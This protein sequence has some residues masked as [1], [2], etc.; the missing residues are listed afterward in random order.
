MTQDTTAAR[1]RQT[2]TQFVTPED[3]LSYELG[4]AVRQLPPLYTRL[5]AGSISLTVFSTIAWAHLSHIDEVAVAPGEL[6]P[7]AQV[8][9][10]RSLEGGV[11]AEILVEEGDLVAAGEPLVVQDQTLPQSDVERLQESAQLV[12]QDIARLQSELTGDD[13]GNTPLQDQLLAARL[14][15][16]R[17]QQATADAEVDRLAAVVGEA[18]A[19]LTQLQRTLPNARELLQNAQ[20]REARLRELSDSGAVARFDY[21][22]AKDRLTE[23]RN[24]VATVEQDI[25]AQ[26]QAVAQ[27]EQEA[28]QGRQARDRL[29]AERRSGILTELNRRTEELTNLEGQLNQAEL[30]ADAKIITAPTAG[31][32]YNIQATLAERTIEPGEELLSILPRDEELLLEAKILNRDIGFVR[33]GMTAKIKLDTFPFQEFGTVSG[34]VTH[35]SPNATVDQQLGPVFPVQIQLDEAAMTIGEQSV[36]LI[37]GMSATAEVVTRRKSVLTFMLEPITRRFGS[38]FSV[39]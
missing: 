12:D 22:E 15:E 34:T 23:A 11:I 24:R 36:E 3:Y 7:S 4:K 38:A 21:I 18:E 2:R 37:P 14:Q 26:Q 32:I 28:R 5:L 16:F 39:R 25:A 20:E 29:T 1:V 31:R 8:R 9:P 6:V 10:V 13:E 35:I 17:E 33:E 27:A 19:R 30:Q